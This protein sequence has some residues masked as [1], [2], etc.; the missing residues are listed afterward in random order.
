MKYTQ[1]KLGRIFILRLEHG[2]KIPDS[3]EDFAEENCIES[4]L[5]HFIGG[6]EQIS[7]IVVGPEDGDAKKPKPMLTNLLGT[8]EAF[9]VGT[10]FLNE[11][12]HPKLHMHAS[13]GREHKALTGCT[14]EGVEIWQIGEV[15][16]QELLQKSAV[17][18]VDSQTGFELLDI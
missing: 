8:S 14:R 10:L 15:V 13:F 5:V 17:R 6:A 4:A 12:R 16:I 2:D 18:K 3:I 1:A 9:G 11:N 7:T